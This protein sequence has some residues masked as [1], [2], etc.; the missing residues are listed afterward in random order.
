MAIPAGDPPS[1]T[2]LEGWRG[3][4]A[5]GRLRKFRLETIA[6]AFQDLGEADLRVRQD[7]AKHLSGAIIG[8][9]RKRVDPK[10]P[11]GGEDIIFEV[12]EV[13]FV[14]L[15]N[16][17]TADG[18]QLRKGFGGIVNFRLKDALA[19]SH[20]DQIV[21]AP[22]PNKSSAKSRK[23]SA[24][25]P[26]KK[27]AEEI[28]AEVD[29]VKSALKQ[30]VA[31]PPDETANDDKPPEADHVDDRP[32]PYIMDD[33]EIDEIGPGKSE[34]DPSLMVAVQNMDGEIDRQ[35]ILAKIPDRVRQLAFSLHMDREPQE[36]TARACGVSTRTIRTWIAEIQED[37]QQTKEAQELLIRRA[38]AKS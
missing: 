6:G 16:P 26:V 33:A 9:L 34:Y 27:T 23:T 8:M 2:D 37:L 22:K 11:N 36:V 1:S 19:Q 13:I 35:R 30:D 4:I 28:A 24:A 25:K 5:D 3:A 18:K 14:A 12:H 17:G 32:P 21:P 29:E 31:D 15:L 20:S 7:L 10:K 38:G